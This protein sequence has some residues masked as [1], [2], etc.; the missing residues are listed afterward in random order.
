MLKNIRVFSTWAI[1]NSG[2]RYICAHIYWCM[3]VLVFVICISISSVF[4][5][6]IIYLYLYIYLYL[7]ECV[8]SNEIDDVKDFSK[9]VFNNLRTPRVMRILTA[10]CVFQPSAL[11]FSFVLFS[12]LPIQRRWNDII[13]WY[14]CVFLT[15]IEVE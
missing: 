12:I 10:P 8:C 7:R 11:L 13:L 14:V 1:M 6:Y 2:A 15:I 5:D 4:I 3:Y 9:S